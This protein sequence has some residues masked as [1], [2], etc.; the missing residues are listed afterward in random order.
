MASR[1]GHTDAARALYRGCPRYER[2]A[3]LSASTRREA[4]KPTL[5]V[6]GSQKGGTTSISF[7]LKLVAHWCGTP[8]NAEPH[9]WDELAWGE[10]SVG[11]KGLRRYLSTYW[12]HCAADTVMRY[13]KTPSLIVSPFA[14]IRVC[15]SMPT[16]RLVAILREPVAR[17]YSGFHQSSGVILP[18]AGI[19]VDAAGFDLVAR[20][21]V[22]LARTCEAT[23]SGFPKRDR[24]REATY[25]QCCVLAVADVARQVR[26]FE[27]LDAQ[28]YPGC[29][30]PQRRYSCTLF[31]DFRAMPVRYSL[32]AQL[33][34]PWY[35]RFEPQQLL[36]LFFE[37]LV[38]APEEGLRQIVT[39]A[40]GKDA[41]RRAMPPMPRSS[42]KSG[43]EPMWA[44]TARL[45]NAFYEPHGRNLSRLLG[46]ALPWAPYVPKG[47]SASA[48]SKRT[49]GSRGLASP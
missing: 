40:T 37:E 45:L 39:F 18:A 41:G 23:P 12:A 25:R 42:S 4:A 34:K 7:V 43:E 33:L 36:V 32:Y 31:G 27:G 16:A 1:V 17:A 3:A 21:D 11:D 30:C 28:T 38:R 26:G 15:Q 19:P 9:F 8:H 14:A 24:G 6:I 49:G 2:S 48:A 13:E 46:K 5:I 10:G 44:G 29:V 22:R 47:S 20:I 35:M